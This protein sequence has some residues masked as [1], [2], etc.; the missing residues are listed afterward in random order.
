[1]YFLQVDLKISRERCVQFLSNMLVTE[2]SLLAI[3]FKPA[4]D[5]LIL[6]KVSILFLRSL[7]V[8][9]C[10]L[11]SSTSSWAWLCSKS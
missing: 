6:T 9:F 11:F 8:T 4:R 10:K 7:R 5:Q 2:R 3:L 1:M